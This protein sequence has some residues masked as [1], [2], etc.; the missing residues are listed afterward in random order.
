MPTGKVKWYDAEKGFGFLSDDDG[1]DVFLHANALPDGRN[2]WLKHG[3]G[4]YYYQAESRPLAE[5]IQREILTFGGLRDDGVYDANLAVVRPTEF[6]AVLIESA[7]LIHPDEEQL[8][9]SDDFLRRLSRAVVRGL[10][11]YFRT[12]KAEK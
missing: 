9:L 3:S 10:A 7:Y 11:A 1:G 12:M 6:P 2:P 4:T 8:L 5:R